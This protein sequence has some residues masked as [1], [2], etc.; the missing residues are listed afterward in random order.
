MHPIYITLPF[1]KTKTLYPFCNNSS[2]HHCTFFSLNLTTLGTSYKWNHIVF[3]FL[4][5]VYFTWHKILKDQ[6]CCSIS[7]FPSCLRLN[8]IPL[9]V[10]TTF[11]LSIHLSR[12]TWLFPPFGYCT[13]NAAMNRR[14]QMSLYTAFEIDISFPLVIYP[15]VELLD[16]M[17][18]LF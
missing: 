1:G 14:V 4:H 5:L 13:M 15:E 3:V 17:V 10:C 2:F 9:Y 11:S 7:E 16:C 6:P 8:N 12:D 18:V